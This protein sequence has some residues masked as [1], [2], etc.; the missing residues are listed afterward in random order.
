MHM[1]N[2]KASIALMSILIISAFTMFLVLTM[3]EVNVTRSYNYLNTSTQ[4]ESL[5][6]AEGCLE[7]AIIRLEQDMAFTSGT[8]TYSAEK[9]CQ[10]TVS[11]TNPLTV[12]IEMS[13]DDYTQNYSAELNVVED[14][15]ANNIHL[16]SWQEI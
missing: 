5:Y 10:I 12:N 14:G 3:S 13:Y 9:T 15:E 2:H 16:S 1:K 6:G 7:E 4:N 8:I 11:G